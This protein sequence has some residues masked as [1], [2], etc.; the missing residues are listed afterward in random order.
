MS[1]DFVY[2]TVWLV[3]VRVGE[4]VAETELER[5]APSL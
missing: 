1:A 4:A 3:N 5:G 2:A